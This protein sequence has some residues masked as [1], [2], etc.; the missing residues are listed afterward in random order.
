M[1]ST[2]QKS[3]NSVVRFIRDLLVIGISALLI[4]FLLKT[5]LIR[6]FFIPSG[7]MQE[8][9]QIED[10][11]MVN[12]LVP[13]VVGVNRGDVVVFKD[14]GGW[15]HASPKPELD[16]LQQALQ[17]VGFAPDTSNDYVIKR[18]IG[19]GGDR[20]QCCGDNG[21]IMVNGVEIDEPYIV[22]PQ[23]EHSASGIEFDVTVPEGSVWL[24]GDNRYAS[25][26]SRYNQDQPGKGFVPESDIVGRAFVLN[27]PL[28]RFTWLGNYPEVFAEVPEPDKAAAKTE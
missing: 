16:W 26:D 7:S 12:Q 25:R 27:W 6:S 3:G 5:F 11:V 2:K 22:I 1:S 4:S 21:K 28:N 19:V 14:P 20:V 24:L 18:V 9:L 8:T 23:G 17:A 13:N 15:L 10:R